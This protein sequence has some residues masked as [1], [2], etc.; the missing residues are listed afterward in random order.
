MHTRTSARDGPRQCHG[1]RRTLIRRLRGPRDLGAFAYDASSCT[2]RVRVFPFHHRLGCSSNTH[3]EK[4]IHRLPLILRLFPSFSYS[5]LFALCYYYWISS[6]AG[7]LGRDGLSVESSIA[8][9]S[10]LRPRLCSKTHLEGPLRPSACVLQAAS[11]R[12]LRRY[13]YSRCVIS[14]I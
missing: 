5:R 10:P 13:H 6:D 7:S 4:N 9:F 3:T 1:W 8:P 12:Y 2:S 11:I 14:H